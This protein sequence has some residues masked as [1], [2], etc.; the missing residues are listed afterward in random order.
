MCFNLLYRAFNICRTETTST[1]LVLFASQKILFAAFVVVEKR[2][3]T[4]KH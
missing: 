3:H 4:G 1:L 2:L